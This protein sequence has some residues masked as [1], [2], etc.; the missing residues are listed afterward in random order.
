MR[1]AGPKIGAAE[2]ATAPAYLGSRVGATGKGSQVRVSFPAEAQS[3]EQQTA[4]WEQGGKPLAGRS[5]C[6]QRSDPA[7]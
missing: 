2:R 3:V 1:A 4:E 5:N 7:R 6:P